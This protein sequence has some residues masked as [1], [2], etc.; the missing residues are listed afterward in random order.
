M[1]EL[2][3]NFATM[4][5]LAAAVTL[6]S[7]AP[8]VATQSTGKPPA[9]K[10]AK[11]KA[12]PVNLTATQVA[13]V[14]DTAG[15]GNALNPP[16]KTADTARTASAAKDD[17]PA[18]KAKN[19]AYAGEGGLQPLVFKLVGLVKAKG[20]DVEEHVKGIARQLGSAT[21]SMADF[22]ENQAKINEAYPLVLAK[23]AEVEA[24]E[25]AEA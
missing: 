15:V 9:D 18:E 21:G 23:I 12:E 13:A 4:T 16:A 10:P 3:L 8:S 17:A 20:L 22:K 5:E 25:V 19:Y 7:G 11:V 24:L 6:L 2:K 14:D 1:Y